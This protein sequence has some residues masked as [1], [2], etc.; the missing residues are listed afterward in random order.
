MMLTLPCYAIFHAIFFLSSVAMFD[1][2]WFCLFH[3]TPDICRATLLLSL[4]TL[5]AVLCYE[6]SPPRCV[7][8]QFIFDALD[9]ALLFTSFYAIIVLRWCCYVWYCCRRFWAR[10]FAR[11]LCRC[12]R[13]CFRFFMMSPLAAWLIL[14]SRHAMP[15]I[16]AAAD[17]ILLRYFR[18]TRC[19][20]YA[21]ALF[22]ASHERGVATC[23]IICHTLMLP[24]FFHVCL[25]TLTLY[26]HY[27][28]CLICRSLLL[29]RYIIS[30]MPA[31]LLL[32]LMPCLL[33]YD[34]PLFY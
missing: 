17:A 4:R 27:W 30:F 22:D 20:V 5:D 2:Y 1:F 26:A 25:P 32:M 11:R 31:Y 23:L 28:F 14:P 16:A 13:S 18:F 3:I 29:F 12:C 7:R 15:H 21:A 19:Y 9:S 33:R 6:L 24:T 34:A 10:F 8:C